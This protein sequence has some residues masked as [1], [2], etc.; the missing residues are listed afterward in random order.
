M[1]QKSLV[2]ILT[3][4]ILVVSAIAIVQQTAYATHLR[5]CP[6]PNHRCFRHHSVDL[7]ATIGQNSVVPIQPD[8]ASDRANRE[9][10]VLSLVSPSQVHKGS[11]V[12]FTGKLIATSGKGV[13]GAQIVIKDHSIDKSVSSPATTGILTI[14]KTDSNGVYK[15]SWVAN[16]S[17]SDTVVAFA[18]YDGNDHFV[19]SIS[20][21]IT[22]TI[23]S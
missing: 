5:D 2:A 14:A 8:I 13:A 7:G 20:K 9:A 18:N 12:E 10:T 19:G 6:P 17:T 3:A 4:T 21:Y 11:T 15:V 1:R 16:G 23:V 22:I